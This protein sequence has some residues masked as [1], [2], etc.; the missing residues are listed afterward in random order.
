VD[1]PG[2]V[3]VNEVFY[4]TQDEKG[5]AETREREKEEKERQDKEA[6]DKARNERREKAR[7]EKRIRKE[8]AKRR[9]DEKRAEEQLR[10]EEEMRRLEGMRDQARKKATA[11]V[12]SRLDGRY[13]AVRSIRST[14]PA[15]RELNRNRREVQPDNVGIGFQGEDERWI[16]NY[17]I[18]NIERAVNVSCS[19]N[20]RLA[21]CYT[22]FREPHKAFQGR[23]GEPVALVLSDQSFPANVPA[24]D[25][26]ECIRVVRVEEGTLHEMVQEFLS[27]VK[28]WMI[29]PGTIIMLG[30]LSQLGK[31]G[32][33]WY[34][35]E[36]VRCRN[37]LKWELGEVLV[38]PLIPLQMN[39][40]CGRHVMRSLAEFM[41]WADD[42]LESEM[43]ILKG[44]RCE[45]VKGILAEVEGKA[46]WADELQNLRMPIS[47]SG[48]GT[49][50][51]K[52]RNWGA[53]PETF[54][55][56]DEHD[57]Q[58]WLGNICRHLNR[59]LN[60]SLA[61]SVASGRTLAAVREMEADGQTVEFAVAGA[62]NADRSVAALARKCVTATKIG[63]AGWSLSVEKD[64]D[65]GI[66]ELKSMG[67]EKKV[68]VFY[69]MDNACFFSMNRTGGSSLPKRVG[70]TYH[71]PGKLVV[72]SGYSLEMLTDEMARVIR[73]VKPLLAV[74]ITP[75][76][77]YLDPC[78]EEHGGGKTEEKRV[79]EQEK[80][81][82]A[83]W[84]LKRETF[85]LLAKAHCKNTIVIG[86][87]EVL[88]VKD[89]VE[90]VRSVMDD[91]VHLNDGAMGALMDQVITK[92]EENL[93]ARK[94][95]PTEKA[96]PAVKKTRVASSGS[97]RGAG[98]GGRGGQG[99]SGG[100][101]AKRTYSAY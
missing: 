19:F 13:Y 90:G 16:R 51:Y 39:E 28:K 100:A 33:A 35:G 53:L 31:Q 21:M 55:A 40:D 18:H 7:E 3:V 37:V 5:E 84:G 71:I 85:Q 75:M 22:C 57:E 86:P 97:F 61:S 79:E 46:R 76:P 50:L 72:A 94:K 29:V 73:E 32:T 91:G 47:L 44:V 9:A 27:M 93:A 43:M 15:G 60:L 6:E 24:M 36:W 59:E 34:A 64:V 58:V 52:S 98:R 2:V 95:G 65:D 14:R 67:M 88:N 8:D 11:G 41:D 56:L 38:T 89:S 49:T 78:C 26:G 63:R 101:A 82:K 80:L 45:Y 10:M 70:R 81:L 74:V 30:S 48:E 99:G 96:G 25:G 69:C 17:N 4:P 68:L 83:V 66:A 23:E 20:P 42:L 62:S 77:R 54:P 12:K 1:G 87:M 92:T